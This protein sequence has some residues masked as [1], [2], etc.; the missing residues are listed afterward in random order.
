MD[1]H[2][3]PWRIPHILHQANDDSSRLK[4]ASTTSG[5]RPFPIERYLYFYS[6]II[7]IMD[8]LSD[9]A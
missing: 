2:A 5:S 7:I 1:H 8:L 6:V 3:R 4:T 9:L